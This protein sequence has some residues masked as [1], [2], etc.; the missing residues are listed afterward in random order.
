MP[1]PRWHRLRAPTALRTRSP[2]SCQC[3]PIRRPPPEVRR[4][5]ISS[6]AQAGSHTLGTNAAWGITAFVV[7]LRDQDWCLA[8]A[9]ANAL[10]HYTLEPNVAI[11]AL[12]ACLVS[13][14]NAL[15]PAA[16]DDDPYHWNGGVSVRSSAA[17]A[18]RDFCREYPLRTSLAALVERALHPAGTP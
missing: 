2:G 7:C 17:S 9:A 12:A 18:L 15:A 1:F 4:L 10:G 6:I 16:T 14:T 5:S 11:P 13:R 8:T 3:Q